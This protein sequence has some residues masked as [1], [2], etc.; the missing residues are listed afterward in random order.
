[1]IP[2]QAQLSQACRCDVSQLAAC[3][4]ST[5]AAIK[6]HKAAQ[7]MAMT[8]AAL[9]VAPKIVGYYI[10]KYAA[11]PMEQLQNLV[12][13]YALGLR[14]LE[15]EETEADTQSKAAEASKG[16]K[17]VAPASDWKARGRR[18]LLR[19]QYSANRS[20]WMSSTEAAVYVHTEQ[21]YWTSH[22][23]VPLARRP[24]C[25]CLCVCQHRPR[26]GNLRVCRAH[27]GNPVCGACLVYR[28]PPM[29]H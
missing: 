12:T 3:F 25:Q 15:V 11:K 29:C 27:C 5:Q 23:E 9:H 2:T 16:M 26:R 20:K 6:A 13:Q 14:R 4:R 8:V 22:N 21:Q 24:R 19:L 7:H 10:T 18:V 28:D 17:L 1:M